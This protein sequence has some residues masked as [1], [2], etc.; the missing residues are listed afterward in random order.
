MTKEDLPSIK[1]IFGNV[2]IE[3]WQINNDK[4]LYNLKDEN[5]HTLNFMELKRVWG[6]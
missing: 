2:K 1:A 6:N 3:I 4:P 5:I